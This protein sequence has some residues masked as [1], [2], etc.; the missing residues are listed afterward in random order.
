MNIRAELEVALAEAEA[1][2]TAAATNLANGYAVPAEPE[3]GLPDPFSDL[4]KARASC[5]A[6]RN[7]L[8][9][10]NIAEGKPIAYRYERRRM[11]HQTASKSVH[12]NR[13]KAIVDRRRARSALANLNRAELIIKTDKLMTGAVN[14]PNSGTT[15][16]PSNLDANSRSTQ[17][18]E[19]LV[20]AV[21]ESATKQLR[22]QKE[23]R[24]LTGRF[25]AKVEDTRYAR[26]WWS[27]AWQAAE[28]SS[29]MLAYLV[30]YYIDVNLQ[31]AMLPP[32]VGSLLV[33]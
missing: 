30:Y 14:D 17:T 22:P 10:L 4:A 7:A 23:S 29:L 18:S 27:L 25:T 1:N 16:S 3:A 28:L 9:R 21:K 2:F 12:A 20:C 31:I 24:R 15:A 13:R 6:A 32:S 8:T 33:G 5:L 26:A 19:H 11:P